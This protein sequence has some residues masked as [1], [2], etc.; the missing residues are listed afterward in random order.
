MH[1]E[2]VALK[3][4]DLSPSVILAFLDRAQQY[5]ALSQRQ[6]GGRSLVL[7]LGRYIQAG[8][9]RLGHVDTGDPNQ[10]CRSSSDLRVV[11]A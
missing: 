1:I 8:F 5:S 3:L 4:T 7:S 9:L 2:P 6:I 11:A 10:T